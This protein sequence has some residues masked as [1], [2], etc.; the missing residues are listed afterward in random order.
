MLNS[1]SR[2][3]V[4][5]VEDHAIVRQGLRALLD[6][7]QDL[8]V[9]G[10]AGDGPQAVR[11]A[12]ELQ[13]DVVLMDAQLPGMPGFQV[14]RT[15]LP[16]CPR[17][18]VLALSI[19]EDSDHIFTMLRAGAKGYVLKQSAAPDL[20]GAIRSI[21]RGQAVLHP[22]VARIVVAEMKRSEVVARIEPLSSREQQILQLMAAGGTSKRI[23]DQLCLSAKTVDNY[24]AR[25]MEKLGARNKVDAVTIGL[26][27]GLI[28]MASIA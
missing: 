12:R 6:R 15:I 11:L 3:R 25:I 26:Q 7:E 8:D 16:A 9:V 18:S 5:L 23:G 13:P 22:S 21:A 2:I 20:A 14:T 24:R 17:T 28:K 4:L 1:T 19:H 27:R 10:E